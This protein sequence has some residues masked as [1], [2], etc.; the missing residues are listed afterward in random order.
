MRKKTDFPETT[1]GSRKLNLCKKQLTNVRSS[2]TDKAMKI[3]PA[4][5]MSLEGTLEY[6]ADDELV[7]VTPKSIRLRKKLLKETDRKRSKPGK[8]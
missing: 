8:K 4:K 1:R 7:E 2:G 6:I 5:K 3:A